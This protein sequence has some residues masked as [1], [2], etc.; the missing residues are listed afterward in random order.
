MSK[1]CWSPGFSRSDDLAKMFTAE[2]SRV[3]PSRIIHREQWAVFQVP[4][5]A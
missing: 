3:C 2:V 4:V 1:L 5:I